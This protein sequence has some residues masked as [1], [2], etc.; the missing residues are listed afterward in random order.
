MKKKAKKIQVGD[1]EFYFHFRGAAIIIN[2]DEYHRALFFQF[3]TAFLK[4]LMPDTKKK[5]QE[6]KKSDEIIINDF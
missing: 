5:K 6:K 1:L 2:A 4:F 3:R